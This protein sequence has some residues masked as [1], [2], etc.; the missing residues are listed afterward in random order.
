[1]RLTKNHWVWTVI[2]VVTVILCATILILHFKNWFSSDNE[3]LKLRSGFYHVVIPY[4][5]LDSV[6]LVD[7]MP[8]MERLNGFSALEKEKG[9]FRE[10]R[11]SLTNK[12]V[13][14]FVDNIS[15]QKVKLVYKDSLYLYF[16][17]KDSVET[18]H[19]FDDLTS[20]INSLRVPN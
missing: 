15:Q 19:L 16:N 1:M 20:K 9:I 14:V 6:V 4:S 12:K 8:A 2:L 18:I 13:H 5:D 7:R 3:S 10:F 11:D 17:L